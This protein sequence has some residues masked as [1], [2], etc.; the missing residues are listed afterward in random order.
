[1]LYFAHRVRIDPDTAYRLQ[2]DLRGEGQDAGLTVPIC[3]KFILHSFECMWVGI[4]ATGSNG[5]W[6]TREIEFNSRNV[7]TPVGRFQVRRPTQLAMFNSNNMTLIE[8]DNLRLFDDR[9]RDLLANGDFEHGMDRWFFSTDSHLSWHIKNLGVQLY[10]ELGAIGLLVFS[11]I[12]VMAL[13]RSFRAAW[14]GDVIALAAFASLVAFLSVG[15]FDSLFDEPRL[16][17]LYYVVLIVAIGRSVD[18][19]G[20]HLGLRW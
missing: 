18:A 17:L 13:I 8:I 19:K 10:F 7:G 15:L 6:V 2:V 1:M 4:K 9:G 5:R 14:R 16:T 20:M 12:T 11:L 3:E